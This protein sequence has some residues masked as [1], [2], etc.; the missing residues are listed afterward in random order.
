MGIPKFFKWITDKHSEIIY[1]DKSIKMN[2]LYLDMN[3]LI[4]PCCHSSD[5]GPIT[6]DENEMI[7]RICNYTMKIINVVKPT[8]LVYMAIDGVAP[9][10][11]ISQQRLRRFKSIKVKN[12]E[13][14]IRKMHDIPEVNHWDSN[15]ITPGT[16]FMYK[17]NTALLKFFKKNN[18]YVSATNIIISDSTVPGEGE[19]KIMEYIR[20]SLQDDKNHCIYGLDA[21]LIMLSLLIENH[22]MFL[23][24]ETQQFY[25]IPC[26]DSPYHYLNINILKDRIYNE[27]V[28]GIG[29]NVFDK[30]YAIL[31]FVFLS[32]L[33]G[34]DFLPSIPSLKIS[35]DGIEILL[36]EYYQ[37]FRENRKNIVI[38]SKENN[39]NGIKYPYKLS[40]TTLGVFIRK[41]SKRE[42]GDLFKI[43]GN[44]KYMSKPSAAS[45]K[46]EDIV[47]QKIEEMNIVLNKYPDNIK[48]A[49]SGYKHRYYYTN[50]R[51]ASMNSY[52]TSSINEICQN[53][54]DGL[55]WNLCYYTGSCPS[56]LWMYKYIHSPLIS[57]LDDQLGTT[58]ISIDSFGKD[59]PVKPLVQ[60]TAVL[61][62][63]SSEIL[64]KEIAELTT[65]L[66]PI[67]DMFPKNF[68]LDYVG[69]KWLW[70]CTP[71]LPYLDINRISNAITELDIDINYSERNKIGKQ[72]KIK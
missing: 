12:M 1:F 64:P 11:K 29:D 36:H 59:K 58:T 54:V 51:M 40:K 13:N 50:F 65:E 30:N 69:K 60:L 43:Y 27:F 68:K 23:I 33:L 7:E 42:E 45:D 8:D 20:N 22:N 5:F 6:K 66:S 57:T 47:K 24:R 25:K 9:L 21:D 52:F 37:M 19:H 26:K 38:E 70:E 63:G 61:P 71:I 44:K 18:K 72:K 10:A 2:S 28:N 41:L 39:I 14:K 3:C 53:Y 46:P 35:N 48:F 67:I 56:W 32:F 4:H 49:E 17:L 34:N 62:P 15:A 55:I 16:N 31:D